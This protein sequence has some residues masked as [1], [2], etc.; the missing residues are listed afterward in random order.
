VHQQTD[1][2]WEQQQAETPDIL[3][4]AATSGRSML[5]QQY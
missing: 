1:V 4:S 3:Q 2:I 5:L